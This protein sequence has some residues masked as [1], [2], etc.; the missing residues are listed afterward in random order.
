MAARAPWKGYT[1]FARDM[2]RRTLSGILVRR[3]NPFPHHEQKRIEC[4]NSTWQRPNRF[5]LE[6][7]TPS[8]EH[9]APAWPPNCEYAPVILVSA[10]MR[11]AKE[12][13][14]ENKCS[15][16]SFG[17]PVK[18]IGTV[19]APAIRPSGERRAKD[20][21][22]LGGRRGFF[23]HFFT[24][25]SGNVPRFRQPARIHHCVSGATCGPVPGRQA[26]SRHLLARI[27]HFARTGC[28]NAS[29]S[30]ARNE[31]PASSCAVSCHAD[32]A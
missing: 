9:R 14:R 29:A 23:S 28:A 27:R 2:P 31:A 17:L 15:S 12:L 20:E 16:S 6:R 19:T 22:M 3:A 4:A 11:H 26:Y 10:P 8:C 30:A 1:S 32:P 25:G 5:G 13:F 21:R 24:G 18:P 7:S